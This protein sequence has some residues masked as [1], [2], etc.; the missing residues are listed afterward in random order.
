MNRL[1]LLRHGESEWNILNKIQGQKNTNLTDRGIIQAK[2][3]AKRL[4]H[5]KIDTIFSSDLNRAFDTAKVIGEFLNLDVNSL[6]ELR[7]ISFGVWEGLTTNEIKEKYRNEHIVWMTKPHNLILPN[8]ESLIDLQER[9]L[10]IVN[11]LIKKNSNKN[12]LIVSHGASIKALILGILGIDISMYNKLSISN[13]GLSIIEYRDYS[14]VLKLLNDTSH[15][16]E[17]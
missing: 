14:P 10:G 6:K 2:Q 1:Y 9:L 7:E 16:R 15:F 4:M 17:V 8:A 5:E 13:T 12:I 11:N 3:A